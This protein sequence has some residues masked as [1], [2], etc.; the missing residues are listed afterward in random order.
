MRGKL[1]LAALLAIGLGLSPR[2]ACAEDR[3][4]KLGVMDITRVNEDSKIMRSLAKQRDKAMEDLKSE[5]E[6]KEKDFNKK[7]QDFQQKRLVMDK[8]AS[9]REEAQLRREMM[10]AEQ[11][12][13]KKGE[14]IEKAFMTAVRKV[15][16]DY[17]DGIMKNVGKK[18]GYDMIISSQAA[19]LINDDLDV[20]KEIVGALNDKITD[21]KLDIK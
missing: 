20:T 10:Q 13:Q 12:L 18:R 4:L 8:D 19:A 7:V 1:A 15:Q 2:P 9:A 17:L 16:H 5:A 3:P 14:A 21:M 6:K 11:E